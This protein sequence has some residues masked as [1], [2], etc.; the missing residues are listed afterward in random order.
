MPRYFT[1]D[2]LRRLRNDI[3]LTV[4]FELLEWP[5]KQRNGQVA[6]LCPRCQACLSAV[7]PRTNLGRCF[8]CQTNFNPID[9]LI[10]AR[11][12]DFVEAVQYLTKLLPRDGGAAPPN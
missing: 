2:L 7:N 9:F 6:F 3:P 10:A 4:I 1:A 5:H 8:H 12:C 11:Q